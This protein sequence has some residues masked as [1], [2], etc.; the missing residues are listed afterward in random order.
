[1]TSLQSAGNRALL[2]MLI[3]DLGERPAERVVRGWLRNLALPPF[4]ESA[5]LQAALESGE[6]GVAIVSGPVIAVH[7]D[8]VTGANLL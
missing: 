6:C 3:G 5:R 7:K 4:K 8:A 1:M 2:A